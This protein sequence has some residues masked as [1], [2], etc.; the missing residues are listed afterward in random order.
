MTFAS[1][2][3]LAFFLLVLMGRSLCRSRSSD[4]WLL[5]LASYAFYMSWSVSSVLLILTVSLVDYHIGRQLAVTELPSDRKRWVAVSLATNL[6]LLGFFKY[7]NF[8]VANAGWVARFFG[9]DTTGWRFDIILPVGISFFVF[10]SLSYTLDVYRRTIQPCGS[11]RDY[12]LF[13]SFFPQ[14]LAGPIERAADLLP[15]LAQ[16]ARATAPELESGLLQF[17]LGAI[18]KLVIAD[19]VAGH[20][21]LIFATPGQYD[22]LTLLQGAAGYTVQI[23]CDFSGYSDMAIGVARIMGY[24]TAENFQ[25]PYSAAN[26]TEFWRRW[27]IS[28]SSWFRDYLFLPSAYT[29]SRLIQQERYLGVRVDLVVYVAA[30]LTTFAACGL[31]HGANWTFVVWGCYHGVALG[32]HRVWKVWRPLKRL[33]RI[34]AFRLG[35]VLAARSVTLTVVVIGWVIFR[36]ES[37]RS[38]GEY[39]TRIVTWESAGTRLPSPYIVPACV[40]VLAAHVLSHKDSNWSLEVPRQPVPVRIM[41]YASIVFLLASLGATDAAPFIYSQF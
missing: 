37:L 10:K 14:L 1:F 8:L 15:Q 34:P 41:W 26:I 30:I 11:W 18:K 2:E 12:L 32:A 21:N 19:Q 20:V 36:A 22:A 39:L 17:G 38:A 28:L 29:F 33:A 13:V 16:R 27:H 6:G 5:L 7:T 23:Y 4:N 24:R 25:M 9:V 3:F 31:W 40:A 35:S